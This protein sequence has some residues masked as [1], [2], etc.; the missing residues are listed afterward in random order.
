MERNNRNQMMNRRK[1]EEEEE[2]DWDED[3]GDDDWEDKQKEK[4][5]AA[6][7]NTISTTAAQKVVIQ[8]FPGTIITPLGP[9]AF[10]F[11]TSSAAGEFALDYFGLSSS[12]AAELEEDGR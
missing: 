12:S 7:E 1:E 4:A 3:W 6:L 5:S 9:S 10:R 11:P 8:F 2:D